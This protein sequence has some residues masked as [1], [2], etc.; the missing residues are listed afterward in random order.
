MSRKI[1]GSHEDLYNEFSKNNK[2]L[3]F[4]FPIFEENAEK[5]ELRDMLQKK[6]QSWLQVNARLKFAKKYRNWRN[7]DWDKVIYMDESKIGLENDFS[8]CI[9]VKPSDKSKYKIECNK[10]VK[11]F[12]GGNVKVW[13]CITCFGP[14]NLEILNENLTGKLYADIL[15]RN[16]FATVSNVNME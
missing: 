1:D 2:A 12:Q 4:Q 8:G 13:G 11:K 5:M 10:G 16:L 14:E 7:E 15:Q 3:T 6:S 9:Y